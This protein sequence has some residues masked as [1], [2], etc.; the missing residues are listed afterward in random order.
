M[1]YSADMPLAGDPRRRDRCGIG[2]AADEHVEA[3]V[4]E[5][6]AQPMRDQAYAHDHLLV[7]A[8]AALRQ[9]LERRPLVVDTFC[10]AGKTIPA[11]RSTS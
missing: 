10:M 7:L 11:L 3:I 5:A 9:V 2:G 6:R 1:I 8:G 4:I